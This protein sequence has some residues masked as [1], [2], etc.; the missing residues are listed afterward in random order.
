MENQQE[1]KE[2]NNIL[3]ACAIEYIKLVVSKMR[4]RK[5]VRQDVQAE[6]AAQFEDE[7]KD[8]ATDEEKEQKAEKLITE[9]GDVKLLAVLLR[10][11][12]K[13]CRPIWRKMVARTFQTVKVVILCLILAVLAAFLIDTIR[14]RS[15]SKRALSLKVGDSKLEVKRVL[16]KPDAVFPKGSDLFDGIFFGVWPMSPERWAYGDIFYWDNEWPY[17][18]PF[19]LRFFA[20]DPDD[21]TIEFD[22]DGK[23]LSIGI[24]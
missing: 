11:A 19:N 18:F 2:K 12:K 9:F 17:F 10:R 24:P 20:P 15:L 4:Y 14:F 6:L 21:L 1:T 8:C 5:K 13:R 3:P 16:D 7:L 22:N 23:V